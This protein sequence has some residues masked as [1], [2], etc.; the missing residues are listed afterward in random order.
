MNILNIT[1]VILCSAFFL[2]YALDVFKKKNITKKSRIMLFLMLAT[3]ATSQIID[4]GFNILSISMSISALA[5]FLLIFEN[6][7]VKNDQN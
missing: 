5:F 4:A 7:K 3:N 1:F 6:S 2:S